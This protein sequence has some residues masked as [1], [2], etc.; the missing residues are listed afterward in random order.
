MELHI[1]HPI[2]YHDGTNIKLWWG[3]Q[4]TIPAGGTTGQVLTKSSNDDYALTWATPSGGAEYGLP[5]G[6]TLG[7]MLVK[8]SSSDYDVTWADP[9]GGGG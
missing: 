1:W 8:A 7:Q 5:S 6:G 3:N 2:Y 4:S 9:S